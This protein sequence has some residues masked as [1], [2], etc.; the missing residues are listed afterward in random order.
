M[1]KILTL[2]IFLALSTTFIE[3]QNRGVSFAG[4]VGFVGE[5][6][7]N[8]FGTHLSFFYPLNKN[9]DLIS[10]LKADIS[11]NSIPPDDTYS[12]IEGIN[13]LKI[14]CIEA[15]YRIGYEPGM[16][17]AFMQF[18][19]GIN[20]N[21]ANGGVKSYE[22]VFSTNGNT[23]VYEPYESVVGF[24]IGLN[25]GLGFYI[26]PKAA[27][28]CELAGGGILGKTEIGWGGLKLGLRFF[29]WRIKEKIVRD[30][31]NK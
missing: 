1:K 27:I 14:T 10:E 2:L 25:V 13:N 5:D 21:F 7:L 24:G 3:A 9:D 20:F 16:D 15:D 12:N 22:S 31:L 17:K 11:Y 23:Y 6:K 19:F 29:P 4:G 26:V 30:W 28:Y 18:G 8:G